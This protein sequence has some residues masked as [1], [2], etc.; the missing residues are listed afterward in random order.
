MQHP[1]LELTKLGK[2]SLRGKSRTCVTT[3][4]WTMLRG[5][6]CSH[7]IQACNWLNS[8]GPTKVGP[9]LFRRV[10]K[11]I[12]SLVVM[13]F[14]FFYEEKVG[15][16]KVVDVG[17][18]PSPTR[19]ASLHIVFQPRAAVHPLAR[20]QGHVALVLTVPSGRGP[21]NLGPLSLV[22]A[23]DKPPHLP[24]LYKEWK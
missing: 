23:S 13:S 16:S 8:G 2:T 10:F 20:N 11:F 3:S 22:R 18:V 21:V 14:L 12:I 15:L 17:S 24:S 5:N 7:F 9:P 6:L 19:K 1:A 4:R